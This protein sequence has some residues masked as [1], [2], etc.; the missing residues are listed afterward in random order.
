MVRELAVVFA[1]T[2]TACAQVGKV[3]EPLV[4]ESTTIIDVRTGSSKA[5]M[6]IV[7]EGDRISDV[8]ES[9]TVQIPRKATV[10]DGRGKWVIPGIVEVHSHDNSKELLARALALGVT[11]MHT[12]PAA[13]DTLLALEGWS[14]E[15]ENPSPRIHLTPWLF[16]GEW[17]DN[18][19]PRTYLVR[20]PL[21]VTEAREY[22]QEVHHHGIR[23]IKMYLEDG[24]LWFLPE[25][26]IPNLTAEVA[27]EV[28]RAA[29]A[30]GIR[31]YAHA[32]RHSFARQALELGVDAL[33]HPVA[34]RV[35]ERSLWEEMKRRAMP[36]TATFG[37]LV[38]YGDPTDY[39]RRVL[40]DSRLRDALTVEELDRF[41]NEVETPAGCRFDLFPT[42]CTNYPAYLDAVTRNTQSARDFGLP[43]ALGSDTEI[44]IGTHL[45]IELLSQA[46]MTPAEIL[47]AA[48]EGGALLLGV[49]GEIGTIEPGKLADLVVLTADPLLDIRNVRNIRFTVKGGKLFEPDELLMKEELIRKYFP[50][51]SS[52]G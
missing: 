34:D 5:G 49:A 16:S 9:S 36:W 48:T 45:E 19:F 40:S 15:P 44:G 37:V 47:R 51:S 13:G 7:V 22:V 3:A 11:T 10:I 31:V 27:H 17:P 8:G 12:M 52:G 46:G 4:I 20:K 24:S 18:I 39:A 43:M 42:L 38:E 28:V 35:V 25:S 33:I 21:T 26:P 30:D 23:Q 6:T 41:E 14:R 1:V 2:A 29:H 50:S 32:W